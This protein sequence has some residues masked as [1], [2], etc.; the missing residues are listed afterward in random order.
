MRILIVEDDRPLRDAI[1]M[2]LREEAYQIDEADNGLEGLYL[3]EQRIHDLI[4]L[5]IMMPGMDGL[6]VLQS[7]RAKGIT[8][9]ILLLT[10]RDSVED[11]VL[12]LDAGADD[13]M[14][15]PFAM[16]ELL[17]R[18]RVLMRRQSRG[19]PDGEL[20][21]GGISVKCQAMEGYADGEPL[22]LTAKEF[23]LMEFLLLNREQILT[24]EQLLD[25]V[26]G[27]DSDAGIGVVDVYVHYLRKKLAPSGYD[28]CIH[29]IR[30]VGY[31]LKE[32]A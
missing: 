11:R 9:P 28:R 22:K 31:M 8:L 18:I 14:I 30:G 24:K 4:V 6:S 19:A 21:Y 32:R 17:A 16:P 5:D 27:I 2:V 3:A 25:R 13:Y 26:W 12:G 7:L 15:K 20:K 1:A 10:A 29:T 23:E